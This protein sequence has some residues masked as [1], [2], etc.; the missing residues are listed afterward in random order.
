M[1]IFNEKLKAKADEVLGLLFFDSIQLKLT[2]KGSDVTKMYASSGI[3]TSCFMKVLNLD[4][5]DPYAVYG[6]SDKC[7]PNTYMA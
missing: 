5:T 6:S 4:Y 7:Y 2:P 1:S 3:D